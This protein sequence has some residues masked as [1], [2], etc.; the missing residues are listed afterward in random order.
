MT[1][2][3]SICRYLVVALLKPLYRRFAA[4]MLRDTS[5]QEPV[6]DLISPKSDE[7]LLA[8]GP[9]SAATAMSLA[10]RFA[11]LN[12][13]VADPNP[14][15][16]QNSKREIVRRKIRNMTFIDAP[17]TT[18]LPLHAGRF[19]R[20]M[21]V[22][23]FHLRSPDE[24]IILAKQVLRILR[25]GGVFYVADYDRPT[26]REECIVLNIAAQISSKIAVQ[27]HIDGTWGQYFK[28]AGFA[29]VKTQSSHSVRIGRVAMMTLRKP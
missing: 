29:G 12:I 22:L 3:R 7:R 2:A 28:E 23:S 6:F 24:K 4:A 18:A 9:G 19:D 17:A 25:H 20:A 13:V 16:V 26:N 15:A 8:F 1:D 21:C 27:S 10:E 5:W 14:S 11:D